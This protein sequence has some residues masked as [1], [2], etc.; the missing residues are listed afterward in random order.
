MHTPT[1]LLNFKSFIWRF[2]Q[3]FILLYVNFIK[4]SKKPVD[5]VFKILYKEKVF[6]GKVAQVARAVES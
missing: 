5:K 4:K 1:K 3:G 2:A 6:D